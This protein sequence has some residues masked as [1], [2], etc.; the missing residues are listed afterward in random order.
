M[1]VIVFHYIHFELNCYHH[2]YV[3]TVICKCKAHSVFHT[4]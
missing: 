4:L 3:I 1:K 2:D